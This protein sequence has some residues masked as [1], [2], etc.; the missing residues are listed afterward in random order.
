MEW[1]RSRHA[2]VGSAASIATGP[3]RARWTPGST[4]G[5][6]LRAGDAEGLRAVPREGSR[7]V[8]AE[9]SRP[10]GRDPRQPR[11]RARGKGRRHAGQH[12][13]RRQRLLAVP[14]HASS[15]SSATRR[16]R[17][18][19]PAPESKPVHRPRHL[20]QQRHRPNQSRRLA[21]APAT[22][23]TRG[24]RFEAKLVAVAGELR[25]VPHGTG[26]SADRDLQRVQARHRLL[27]QPRPDG[28]GQG[29]RLG[30]GRGLLRRAHLRHVPHRQLHD[31]RTATVDGNSH[32][33]GERI[34]WTLR[35]V[36][37]HQDQ[38]A[39]SS[40]TASRRTTRTRGRCR[41]I[42]DTV[43]TT[44]KVVENETLV[45]RKVTR[46]VAR[47]RHLAGAARRHEGRLPQLPQRHLRGQLLQAVSTT[48]SCSTT[49]SSPAR[50]KQLMDDL[51]ADG[52]LKPNAPFEHE[53]AVDL[54]RALAPRRPT[55]PSRRQHDGARLHA[56]ARHVRGGQALL[57][58][59]P[60]AG[61]RDRGGRRARRLKAEVPKRRSPAPAGQ[62]RAPLEEGHDP[63]RGRS[64]AQDLQRTLHQLSPH[65]FPTFLPGPAPRGGAFSIGWELTWFGS[66]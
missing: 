28:A 5:I 15:S 47:D 51:Q 9:P 11:Q 4:R 43:E 25:Q 61:G 64:P 34:S 40:R 22:P 29:R 42:G 14:R 21:R 60:P 2:A 12:R 46:K 41:K 19:A 45:T 33:V 6:H 3:R 32:D 30:A 31:R 65:A 23:A 57:H 39:S 48:W 52:V 54:L 53:A 26:P 62:G 63:G 35:P 44:E 56:L 49:T 59:V 17:S 7:A 55:R 37:S 66:R 24:I 36:V 58:R 27:R 16:A 10:G 38:P 13:R 1:E 50:R 18:F 8:F 20:A